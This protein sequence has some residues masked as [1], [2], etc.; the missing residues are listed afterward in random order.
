MPGADMYERGQSDPFASDPR[1]K[2]LLKTI[3]GNFDKYNAREIVLAIYSLARM[4][5]PCHSLLR[6]TFANWRRFNADI[7]PKDTAL[8]A[9]AVV[10]SNYDNREDHSILRAKFEQFM[11]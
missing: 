6:K 3:E 1:V 2:G 10:R 11:K 4:R 8:I 7:T 5:L 9:F